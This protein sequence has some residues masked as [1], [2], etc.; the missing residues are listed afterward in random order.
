MANN[1]KGITIE[2]G[3]DT[4][5]LDKALK[6]V[7]KTSRNLQSELRE[8]NKALKLDPKNT[9]LLAQKQKLL[10]EA[11][12]NTKGKL[13][14]LKEAEKQAQEQFKQGKISEEQYRGL[15]RE[16]IKTGQELKA[17]EKNLKN[18]NNA[19]KDFG[20]QAK[21]IGDKTT[22]IGKTMS[23]GLTVPIMAIGAA[24][25][26]AWKEV[27]DALDT[28]TTKTGATGEAAKELQ[29][30]FKNVASA[31]PTDIKTAG[32]AVGE[33]NTQFGLMGKELDEATT[34]FIKFA[35]INGQ[36]VS[37]SAIN[38]RQAIEAYGLS[39]KDLGGVLDAV[40]KAAQDTGQS[41]SVLFDKVTKG[42]P[43]IKAL[44]LNFAQATKLVGRFE[45]KGLD[46]SKA[47]SYLSKAQVTF[48]K[49]GKTLEQGLEEITKKIQNSKSETEALTAA[50]QIFGSKGATFMV[51]AIK[52]GALSF[53]DLVNA[54][55]NA[56]GAVETTFDATLDPIDK[57]T[58]AMNNLKLVGADLGGTI[59][60][61]L[62]PVLEKIV[63]WLQKF[64]TWFGGLSDKTKTTIVVIAGIVAAIGPLLI[65]IGQVVTAIGAISTAIGAAGGAMA[66][67]TGPIGIVIAAIAALI[68]IGVLLYKNWDKI[69]EAGGKL[70]G[71][72]K[73][74][75]SK[76]GN[77]IS[78]TWSNIKESTSKVWE[79][80][81]N[82]VAE[83]G[84]GIKGVIGTYI[85]GYKTIWSKGFSFIDNLTGGK[86]GNI[87]NSVKNTFSKIGDTLTGWKNKISDIWNKIWNF[88]IPKIKLPHFSITG[89]LNPIDWIKQGVPK[90]GVKWYDRGGIFKSPTVIGVGEKRPEF[91]GALE[92]LRYLI[93]DELQKS[94]PAQILFQ[95]N[96][97]FLDDET[98]DYFM[99]KAAILVERKRG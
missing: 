21:K 29:Q 45:Q 83:H 35:N 10:T 63:G 76:I 80:M 13:E 62:A 96:Y 9:D 84:G 17:L 99:N 94:K 58:V 41:T 44:G 48:A 82:K 72:I 37:Q 98:V 57:A 1:I 64:A 73:D 71:G 5:P 52:R 38:A 61:A 24:S 39:T 85:E 54:S 31:V 97:T 43:Q 42:A 79:G 46:S 27:D 68:A 2:I 19:W 74:T 51:D 66:I 20:E 40:T 77:H 34:K 47:L 23:K 8:V 28:I 30:S 92:D 67:L 65:I 86:L 89:S 36:D 87:L 88:K 3:G 22:S 78:G 95:G 14:T 59:Q 15:Q 32:D 16:V 50:S 12:A 25:Q 53:E 33:V 4:R 55:Q 7:N 93:R 90:L 18:T 70:W 56:G 26:V 6:D 69:K 75:F 11:V 91:V 81:K 60:E 49:D